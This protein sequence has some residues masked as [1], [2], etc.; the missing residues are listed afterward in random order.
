MTFLCLMLTT[1]KV[2]KKLWPWQGLQKI[3]N[4]FQWILSSLLWWRISEFLL[5]EQWN[6][7]CRRLRLWKF[8]FGAKVKIILQEIERKEILNLAIWILN[9]WRSYFGENFKKLIF[10]YWRQLIKNLTTM[11]AE[12][13]RSKYFVNILKQGMK[14]M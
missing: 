12:L 13:C 9:L 11:L 6:L 8:P 3:L 10:Y 7:A 5:V 4:M 14:T 1:T 2:L